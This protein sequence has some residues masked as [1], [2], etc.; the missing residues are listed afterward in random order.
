MTPANGTL[1]ESAA[2]PRAFRFSILSSRG[3]D[4]VEVAAVCLH[5]TPNPCNFSS[6]DLCFPSLLS[7]ALKQWCS[8]VAENVPDLEPKMAAPFADQIRIDSR[9]LSPSSQW[10]SS[11]P[12]NSLQSI[13]TQLV[14]LVKALFR[15]STR[16]PRAQRRSGSEVRDLLLLSCMPPCFCCDLFPGFTGELL[17]LLSAARVLALS[18]PFLVRCVEFIPC[19]LIIQSIE[20]QSLQP[21]RDDRDSPKQPVPNSGLVSPLWE[22]NVLNTAKAQAGDVKSGWNQ[23]NLLVAVGVVRGHDCWV[24]G[25]S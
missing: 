21:N 1:R 3:L 11:Q 15:R 4:V 10:I 20:S 16:F 14:T 24:L 13:S 18:A 12:K 23:A 22:T 7:E 9:P 8:T 19:W 5:A 17:S 2:S 6:V 25:D